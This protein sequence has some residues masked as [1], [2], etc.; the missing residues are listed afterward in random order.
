MSSFQRDPVFPRD[1]IL[2]AG[3]KDLLELVESQEQTERVV[4][5]IEDE[6]VLYGRKVA[7]LI[8]ARLY[9]TIDHDL[10]FTAETDLVM[11]DIKKVTTQVLKEAGPATG[12]DR[13]SPWMVDIISR[14]IRLYVLGLKVVGTDQ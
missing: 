12:R 13:L 7:P 2:P 1:P 6:V 10:L 11:P 4:D 5:E 3:F 9:R 8:F 14:E